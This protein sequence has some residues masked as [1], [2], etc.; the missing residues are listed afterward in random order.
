MSLENQ[1][2]LEKTNWLAYLSLHNEQGRNQKKLLG[3][4]VKVIH[5]SIINI[6]KKNVE[7]KNLT[8]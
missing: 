5:F 6:Y 8:N 3:G 1:F 2:F 4:G 7:I